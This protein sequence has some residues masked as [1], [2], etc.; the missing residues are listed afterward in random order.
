MEKELKSWTGILMG[1]D[2][3]GHPFWQKVADWLNWLFPV[4]SALKRTPVQDFDFFPL[5]F[6]YIIGVT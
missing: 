1:A 6:Y 4:R 5:M 3:T 2:L